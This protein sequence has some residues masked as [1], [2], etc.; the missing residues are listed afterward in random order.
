MLQFHRHAAAA[1]R[2]A[3]SAAVSGSAFALVGCSQ[4]GPW[5]RNYADFDRD[6]VHRTAPDAVNVRTADSV[7]QL[8]FWPS[9]D[10][11]TMI[12]QSKFE[13]TRTSDESDAALQGHLRDLAAAHGATYV[14]W[15]ERPVGAA[16]SRGRVRFEYF[17]AFYRE[18]ELRSPQQAFANAAVPDPLFT[19]DITVYASYDV[20]AWRDMRERGREDAP[21]LAGVDVQPDPAE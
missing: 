1:R 15:C 8:Q 18:A 7:Q 10:G 20:E 17:A 3:F 12:G 11:Y 2:L 19:R 16:D 9:V 4:G 13:R 5:A 21:K 14:R 6:P